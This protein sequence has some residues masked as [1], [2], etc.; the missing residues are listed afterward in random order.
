MGEE[1]FSITTTK[2]VS[3]DS[4]YP[5]VWSMEIDPWNLRFR[6]NT[7]QSTRNSQSVVFPNETGFV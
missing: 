5:V 6:F 1:C 7:R 4:S 3:E 2:I